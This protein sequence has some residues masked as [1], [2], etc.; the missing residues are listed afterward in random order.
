MFE[1]VLGAGDQFNDP[2]CIEAKSL[3]DIMS[4]NGFDSIDFLKIDIEGAEK[5]LFEAPNV[6]DWL[7]KCRVVS[8]E[9]HDRMLP[10][11]SEA[12]YKAV[13]KAGFSSAKH[14]EFD[15]FIKDLS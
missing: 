15:Y 10:G 3:V 7:L 6:L 1:E 9:L 4:L 5:I 12:V 2:S 11:C 8:C 13:S 14:C